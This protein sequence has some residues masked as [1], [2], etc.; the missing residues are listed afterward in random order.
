MLFDRHVVHHRRRPAV[1]VLT[2]PERVERPLL[3]RQPGDHAGL[4]RGEVTH[5][6]PAALGRDERRPD[7]LRE[8]ERRFAEKCLQRVEVSLRRELPC[9]I[10]IRERVPGQVVR[11]HQPAGPPPGAVRSV[12]LQDPA[13]AAVRT[14]R[15]EH[16]RIFGRARLPEGLP[17]LEHPADHQRQISAQQPLQVVLPELVDRRTLLREPCLELCQAVGILQAGQL[18]DLFL[19]LLPVLLVVSDDLLDHRHVQTDA[20]VVHP[21]IELPQVL[22]ALREREEHRPDRHLRHHVLPVVLDV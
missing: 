18:P 4:D 15:L 3:I 22:L 8:D 12:E 5:H 20:A 2:G 6:E 13:Q 16:R 10:K 7:Q 14:H 11:L 17:D 19:Q 1:N 21:L 9:E